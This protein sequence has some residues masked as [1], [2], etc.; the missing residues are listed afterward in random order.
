MRCENDIWKGG[1][2]QKSAC[3]CKKGCQLAGL[4]VRL[5]EGITFKA[6]LVASTSPSLEITKA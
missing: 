6:I 1:M 5:F 4:P 2:R 3:T